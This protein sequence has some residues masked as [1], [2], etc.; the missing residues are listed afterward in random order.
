MNFVFTFS[1]DDVSTEAF[2]SLYGTTRK[3]E[4][5]LSKD[6]SKIVTPLF[7]EI[8]NYVFSEAEMIS[9][10]PSKAFTVGNHS[11]AFNLPVFIEV[12]CSLIKNYFITF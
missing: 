2:K 3:N 8:T 12:M 10:T 1:K 7:E 4:V 9:K 11:L 5:D 6:K